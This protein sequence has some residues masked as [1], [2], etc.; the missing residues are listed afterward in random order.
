[1]KIEKIAAV[2]E[3]VSSVAIVITLA[4]LAI[5][6]QQTNRALYASSRQATMMA[7]VSMVSAFISNPGAWSNT[8]LPLAELDF[9]E[10]EQVGNAVAGLLRVREFAWFQY[11]SGIMDEAAMRSYV[12]PLARWLRRGDA[13]AIWAQVSQEMDP[14]FVEYVEQVLD[15]TSP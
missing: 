13:G 5:Q 9:V 3:I 11:R 4:Y 15:E 12:A 2:A 8:S 10:R 1:M 7:D 6:T 14:E